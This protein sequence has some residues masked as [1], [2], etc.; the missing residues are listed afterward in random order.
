M[1]LIVLIPD[2]CLLYL[3][4]LTEVLRENLAYHLLKN[5]IYQFPVSNLD[6]LK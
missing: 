1:N 3:L 5:T 2:L 6:I 4:Y